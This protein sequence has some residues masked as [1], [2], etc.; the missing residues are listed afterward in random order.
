MVVAVKPLHDFA[1]VKRIVVSTYQAV[2][3]KGKDALVELANQVRAHVSG[4]EIVP[5][6][7]P[8]Q[9]ALPLEILHKKLLQMLMGL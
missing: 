5:E 2:S 3:G 1:C 9:I 8:Y 4:D 7:F 6:V